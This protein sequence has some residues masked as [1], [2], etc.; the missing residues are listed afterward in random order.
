[1]FSNSASC[2]FCYTY[3]LKAS[4]HQ[5]VYS[6]PLLVSTTMSLI[7]SCFLRR[8]TKAEVLQCS[9]LLLLAFLANLS[10]I[11][12]FTHFPLTPYNLVSFYFTGFS[13]VAPSPPSSL[14]HLLEHKLASPF[15]FLSPSSVLVL[16]LYSSIL[17]FRFYLFYYFICLR[18]EQSKVFIYYLQYFSSVFISTSRLLSLIS[19]TFL[20]AMLVYSIPLQQM[21]FLISLPHFLSPA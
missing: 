20:H 9:P 16:H 3:F 14:P 12:I 8:G 1:M 2:C 21:T 13:R 10:S 18:D 15:C 17:L 11:F 4:R 19:Y 7:H 6:S 5:C